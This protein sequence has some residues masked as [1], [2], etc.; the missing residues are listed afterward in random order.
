MEFKVVSEEK[1][2]IRIEIDDP[3]DT[4]LNP[5]VSELLRASD[6]VEARYQI[7]HPQLDKP[8]LIIKT[9][10][11][12]PQAALKKAAENLADQYKE[13]RKLLEKELK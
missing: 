2:T 9:K 8:L 13:A 10:K 6:V 3:D 4:L 5:L 7:G 1:N 11:S 12:K